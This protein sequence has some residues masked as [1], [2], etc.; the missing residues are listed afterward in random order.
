MK[1][2]IKW[3]DKVKYLPN[4]KMYNEYVTQEFTIRDL[5]TEAALV[6]EQEI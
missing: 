6:L 4:F 3:D 5:L 1:E 2:K